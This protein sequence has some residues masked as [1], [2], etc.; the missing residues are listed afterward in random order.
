[1]LAGKDTATEVNDAVWADTPADVPADVAA[2]VPPMFTDTDDR[3]VPLTRTFAATDPAD[4]A[5][6]A[7]VDVNVHVDIGPCTNRFDAVVIALAVAT[8]DTVIVEPP[9]LAVAATL[10]VV[11]VGVVVGVPEVNEPPMLMVAAVSVAESSTLCAAVLPTAVK[12]AEL[13]EATNVATAVAKWML[14]DS[15]DPL[16]DMVT[17][18]PLIVTPVKD[19][20]ERLNVATLTP[21]PL[22]AALGTLIVYDVIAVAMYPNTA[23]L[24]VAVT[25]TDAD[26]TTR[27]PPLRVMAL[28]CTPNAV[29]PVTKNEDDRSDTEDDV[30]VPPVKLTPLDVKLD[31][32]VMAEA[33]VIV[34]RTVPDNEIRSIPAAARNPPPFTDIVASLSVTSPFIVDDT[35]TNAAAM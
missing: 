15:D 32:T 34:T 12:T 7:A 21:S 25:L 24:P 30:S 26:D 4:V 28:L 31:V 33:V 27:V 14:V 29:A 19:P 23:A 8:P 18:V 20:L 2:S 16:D 17:E 3:V 9:M 1:M 6:I 13:Q 10:T 35:A 22:S 5:V 11:A